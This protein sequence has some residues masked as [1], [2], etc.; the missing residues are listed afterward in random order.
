[1]SE[2]EFRIVIPPE[3]ELHHPDPIEWWVSN[4]LG[5]LTTEELDEAGLDL[6]VMAA[7]V[8]AVADIENKNRLNGSSPGTPSDIDWGF[9]LSSLR[10]ARFEDGV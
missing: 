4:C 1:M 6:D 8:L 10:A 7:I 5:H 3:I 2:N 9:R